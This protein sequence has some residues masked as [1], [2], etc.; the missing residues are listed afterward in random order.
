[1]GQSCDGWARAALQLYARQGRLAS[2]GKWQLHVPSM[3]D[4]GQPLAGFRAG[5]V[6]AA[7]CTPGAAPESART[8]EWRSGP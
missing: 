7:S 3:S 8:H 4:G 5:Q 6:V 1:V 2:H